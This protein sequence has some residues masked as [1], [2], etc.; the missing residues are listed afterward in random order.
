MTDSVASLGVHWRTGNYDPVRDL[1]RAC[2]WLGSAEMGLNP[3]ELSKL[4]MTD[5]LGWIEAASYVAEKRKE[6]TEK[7]QHGGK[8]W[9]T[10]HFTKQ[11]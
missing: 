10:P 3:I 4:S 7:A 1:K 9:K 8:Q 11:R 2:L 6:Q 5:L